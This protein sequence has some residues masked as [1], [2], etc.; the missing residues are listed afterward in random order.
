MAGELYF[1]LPLIFKATGKVLVD[2]KPIETYG[3]KETDHI[4][5]MVQKVQHTLCIPL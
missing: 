4:I 5:C 2:D 3:I 1:R